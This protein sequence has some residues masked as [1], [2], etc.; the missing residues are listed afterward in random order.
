MPYFDFTQF[1]SCWENEDTKHKRK[2]QTHFPLSCCKMGNPH[3][4]P[5]NLEPSTTSNIL[6]Q[7]NTTK[8]VRNHKDNN[9]QE[10]HKYLGGQTPIRGNIH[11]CRKPAPSPS[12]NST[13]INGYTT[14]KSSLDQLEAYTTSRDSIGIQ[15]TKTISPKVEKPTKIHI[16]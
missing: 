3:N 15:Q 12:T 8:S 4:Q 10:R 1:Q 14:S 5:N 2:Q 7:T 11:R 6:A 16:Y 9:I 13:I